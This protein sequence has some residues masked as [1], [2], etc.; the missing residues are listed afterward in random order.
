M[1]K[2]RIARGQLELVVSWTSQTASE[3]TWILADEFHIPYPS[4]QL[5]DELLL[6]GG[7]MSCMGFHTGVARKQ[8]KPVQ[9]QEHRDDISYQK[10]LVIVG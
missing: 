7:E 5:M 10:I 3:A 9:I 6:Q 4:Y 1:L 2:S 8:Q